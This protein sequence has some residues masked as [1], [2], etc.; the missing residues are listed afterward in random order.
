M[1]QSSPSFHND[2]YAM[3]HG[4]SQANLQKVIVSYPG[5]GTTDYGLTEAGRQQVRA[6]ASSFSA[7]TTQ[8]RIY[9][10]DF[11]RARETARLVQN[12]VQPSCE[13]TLTPLLRERFFGELE[14]SGDEAYPAVW[15]RD[16]TD[17]GHTWKGVESVLCVADRTSELLEELEARHNGA[18]ILLVAHGD[19]L[20]ILQTRFASVPPSQYRQLP[21][22]QVAEIRRL[23]EPRP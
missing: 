9:S 4:E 3:R 16:A 5:T 23:T 21:H 7:P 22:L 20:Q 6:S 17:P 19:V 10:S 18:N 14:G 13:L 12:I 1:P 8:L 11:L 15:S 2:Y